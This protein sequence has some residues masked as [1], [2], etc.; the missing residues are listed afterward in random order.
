MR[1]HYRGIIVRA[2][3]PPLDTVLSLP[4]YRTVSHVDT[5]RLGLRRSYNLG[6][7][8]IDASPSIATAL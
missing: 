3:A 8:R 7:G 4:L 2:D 5:T 6:H 1:I